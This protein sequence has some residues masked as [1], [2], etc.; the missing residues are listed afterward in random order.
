MVKEE[1][2]VLWIA[3]ILRSKFCD[4][5]TKL[6]G[7]CKTDFEKAVGASENS[8][9]FRSWFDSQ[10]QDGSI[11]FFEKRTIGNFGNFV[12]TYIARHD[13]F[14]KMWQEREIYKLFLRILE[15]EH[16]V[17]II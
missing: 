7:G 3:K 9:D 15:D 5:R 14:I 12:D 17:I 6:F 8:K 16:I 1:K 2:E 10:V 4:N 13:S 11:V